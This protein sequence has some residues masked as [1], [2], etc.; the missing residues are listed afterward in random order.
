MQNASQQHSKNIKY[1]LEPALKGTL[2]ALKTVLLL[3]KIVIPVTIV[4]VALDRL[5]WL[6]TVAAVF[7]PLLRIFGLPGEA[8]LPLLLGFFVNFYA[9]VGAIAVLS[10]SARQIT[11]IGLMILTCHSLLMESPVLK[12]TGLSPLVS[13]LLRIGGA[14]VFGFILNII[15]I[16]FGG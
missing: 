11:V 2:K 12:F 5:G 10:L 15:L 6:V 4:L 9:A 3:S 7:G 1:Y 14:L 8:A 13:M 16:V